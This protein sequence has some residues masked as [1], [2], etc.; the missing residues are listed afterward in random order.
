MHID[1]HFVMQS[2]ENCHTIHCS[3][4]SRSYWW[5]RSVAD[6]CSP[7]T[8]HLAMADWSLLAGK[9]NGSSCHWR[10]WARN[11]RMM[12]VDKD[13]TSQIVSTCMGIVLWGLQSHG[14][15]RDPESSAPLSCWHCWF[16]LSFLFWSKLGT[17][18]QPAVQKLL[19]SSTPPKANCHKSSFVAHQQQH[20]GAWEREETG[21]CQRDDLSEGLD[22]VLHFVYICSGFKQQVVPS[23]VSCVRVCEWRVPSGKRRVL[24]KSVAWDNNHDLP[25]AGILATQLVDCFMVLLWK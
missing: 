1:P 7:A 22:S 23:H 8:D 19:I 21:N 5:F 15:S 10:G 24:C 25:S 18:G 6:T 14:V 3:D 16:L 17:W 13:V 2:V 4:H 9:E 20:G 11:N 12:V